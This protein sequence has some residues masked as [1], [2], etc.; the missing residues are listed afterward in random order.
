MVT[1]VDDIYPLTPLQQGLLFHAAA[2]GGSMYVEQLACR[3]EGDFDPGAFRAAWEQACK[4]HTTLRT[5][6]LWENL[7]EPVQVVRPRVALPWTEIDWRGLT[8]EEAGQ[9]LEAFLAHDRDRGL[10][11]RKAPLIRITVIRLAEQVY[12][13][14]C[15]NHHLIFDGWSRSVL[16]REVLTAYEQLRRGQDA[17]LPP[18]RPYREFVAWLLEQEAGAAEETWRTALAGIESPTELPWDPPVAARAA[19]ADS[20]TV[21]V[22]EPVGIALRNLCS[23]LGVTLG[24]VLQAAWGVLLARHSGQ[25]GVLFGATVSG[26]PAEL[27]GVE[28]MVGLFINTLPIRLRVDANMPVGRWLQDVQGMLVRLREHEHTP[29]TRIQGW[30][31]I[32]R[33]TAM[34]GTVVVV[35]NQPVSANGVGQGS[36][37]VLEPRVT[38]E[39]DVPLTLIAAPD[40]RPQLRLLFRTDS[41][42][43]AGALRLLKQLEQVLAGLCAGDERPL[44]HVALL[45]E[46]EQRHQVEVL[47]PDRCRFSG[48]PAPVTSEPTASRTPP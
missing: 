21:E 26:R 30:S 16:F 3:L 33:G 37:R 29:L 20:V 13:V 35:E 25:R 44:S 40:R 42:D 34:F 6:F 47:N 9:Q 31:S 19:S 15:T 41:Y 8:R 39:T 23:R 5:L 17:V 48:L 7:A 36:V 38:D 12:E 1:N 28:E 14:V 45:D 43:R 32:P 22:Q 18:A 24:T 10:D 2:D 27:P 11:V 46:A 4:R